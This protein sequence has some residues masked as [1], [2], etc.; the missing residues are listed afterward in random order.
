[1]EEVE[2]Y[3]RIKDVECDISDI[4]VQIER[5]HLEKT[6]RLYELDELKNAYQDYLIKTSD[7]DLQIKTQVEEIKPKKLKKTND[8]P[9][10][11]HIEV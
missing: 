9:S 5:L 10:E 11:N 6:K 7:K 8:K 2:L 1:M 3:F 4:T